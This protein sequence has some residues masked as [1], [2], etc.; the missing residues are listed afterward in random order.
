MGSIGSRG[1]GRELAVVAVSALVVLASGA[2]ARAEGALGDLISGSAAPDSASGNAGGG[3]E[4]ALEP[5]DPVSTGTT[6]TRDPVDVP[7]PANSAEALGL[8][9]GS[10]AVACSG[11]A[12]V[13]SSAI[14]SGL[15]TGS[16][17]G[18]PA[19]IGTGSGGSGLGSAAVGSAAAGS[20]VLTCVLLLPAPASAQPAI[21]LRLEPPNPAVPVPNPVAPQI[22]VAPSAAVHE[23]GRPVSAPV[24]RPPE[25][26]RSPPDPLA[27]N[28]LELVTILVMT[29]VAGIRTGSSGANIRTR[30]VD[31]D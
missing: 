9:P 20:A 24:F 7:V 19:L 30:G 13:G 6:P 11:S 31:V 29:V 5:A 15:A 4:L 3:V 16:G 18:T 26:V 8:D 21:P 28:L 25:A 22:V 17:S 14:G 27:W 2:T 1:G 12:A 23:V 10:V